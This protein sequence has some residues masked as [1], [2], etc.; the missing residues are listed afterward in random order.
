MTPENMDLSETIRSLV[1]RGALFVCNHSGGK[2]SQ[3]MLHFL[4]EVIPQD[5]LLVVHADLSEVE[6]KGTLEHAKKDAGNLPFRVCKSETKTFLSMVEARGQFP[7]PTI[8]Q[9][10]SDLKRGP[11]EKAIRHYLKEPGNEHFL[12]RGLVVNCMGMRAEE[13][14]GRKKL[15]PFKYNEG[16]SKAGREWYDWLPVHDMKLEQVWHILKNAKTDVHWAYKRGM[17]RLSCAFCIMSSQ[18]DLRTA[19]VHNPE[20]FKRYVELERKQGR[21]MLMPKK[22]LPAYLEDVVGMTVDEVAEAM[23]RRENGEAYHVRIE[24]ED[25]STYIDVLDP[26]CAHELFHSRLGEASRTSLLSGEPAY[27]FEDGEVQ[28]YLTK[29]EIISLMSG[30]MPQDDVD[31]IEI[32]KGS[33][34]TASEMRLD[35]MPYSMPPVPTTKEAADYILPCAA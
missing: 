28:V 2:D 25:D 9:C 10:Q 19:A 23:R 30:T 13:S 18:A 12:A 32:A 8:K 24:S 31:R 20:L 21:S 22:G 7:S 1:D 3:V 4:R 35:M 15:N 6:W 16:N 11:L 27:L 14:P 5:Q 17:S 29:E 26:S 34:F 33:M